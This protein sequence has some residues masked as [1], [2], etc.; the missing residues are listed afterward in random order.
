M[1]INLMPFPSLNFLVPSISAFELDH[2]SKFIKHNAKN[3]INNLFDPE[4]NLCFV[5][6][7]RGKY[8]TN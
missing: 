4:F 7:T 1:Y 5:T 6:P 3:L 2:S 8:F